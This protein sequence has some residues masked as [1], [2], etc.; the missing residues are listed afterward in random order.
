MPTASA[1]ARSLPAR[2]VR[3]IRGLAA[4]VALALTFATPG[5]VFAW[6]ANSFSS[7]DEALLVQLTNQ[8]RAS[9]G[10]KALT[11]DST[12]AGVAR[13]RS[14]DMIER[15]YFS[16]T[17]PPSNTKV[18]DELKRIGYCYVAAG[19]NIGTNN[20]PD[21]IAT[22]TIQDGFMG[23]PGHRANILG[24]DWTVLGVGAYKGPDGKHMWTVLFA[25]KCGSTPVATLKPTPKPTPA[26]TPKPAASPSVV[27]AVTPAP[28]PVPTAAPTPAPTAAPTPAPTAAPTP[29]PTAT[30]TPEPTP[31]PTPE[32]TVVP[33][34][35]DPAE[36]LG[37]LGSRLPDRPRGAP[38]SSPAESR[39]PAAPRAGAVAAP[40]GLR[41]IDGAVAG[42]LV[43]TI[44]GDVAGAYFGH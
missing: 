42:N 32:P 16:H 43:D 12:L 41:V 11:V 8:A 31:A 23:S 36:Q 28:T 9:A 17:I 4:L 13:W 21:D 44:V 22:S 7:S 39:S 3:S 30:P 18:F 6:D 34:E 24:T 19:E 1:R 5:L 29:A 15:N 25:Q 10:L 38:Q 35:Q 27:P 33:D 2:P 14:Q 20:F 40:Q 26:P 37:A